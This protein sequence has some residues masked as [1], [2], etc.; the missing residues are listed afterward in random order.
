M[1]FQFISKLSAVLLFLMQRAEQLAINRGTCVKCVSFN[2]QLFDFEDATWSSG[3]WGSTLE[4]ICSRTSVQL[5]ALRKL[6]QCYIYIIRMLNISN[7][8]HFE[9]HA[10]KHAFL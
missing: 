10:N 4:H 2:Q 5:F 6:I 9:Q 8:V 7:C 1:F 3:G